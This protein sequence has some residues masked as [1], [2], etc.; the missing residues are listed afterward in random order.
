MIDP[1]W[2]TRSVPAIDE[3]AL[4]FTAP[5]IVT[6]LNGTP[7]DEVTVPVPANT[8]VPVPPVNVAAPLANVE[9][10]AIVS[11]PPEVMSIEPPL[12]NVVFTVSVPAAP[13]VSELAERIVNVFGLFP[14]TPFAVTA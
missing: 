5:L 1:L 4:G 14:T 6:L 3:P 12:V 9:A 10:F 7:A 8:T 13:K 2:F 11:T